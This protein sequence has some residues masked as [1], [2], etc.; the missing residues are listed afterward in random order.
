MNENYDG[1]GKSEAAEVHGAMVAAVTAVG[2]SVVF[3]AALGAVAWLAT[4]I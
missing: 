3:W 4:T 1:Q 2:A